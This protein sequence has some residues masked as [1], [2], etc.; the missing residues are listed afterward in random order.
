MQKNRIVNKQFPHVIEITRNVDSGDPFNTT[1]T[2]KV[3]YNGIGRSF[4]ST[5]TDGNGKV[6]TNSR[7]ASIPVKFDEWNEPVLNK[8]IIK[9]TMGNITET[10]VV[11]D[12]SA[13]NGT[14]TIYWEEHTR[15]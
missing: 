7:Q 2:E 9:V 8:D 12:M 10:G 11:L 3:I 6:I 5:T 1:D 14:T 4:T 15:I 13:N